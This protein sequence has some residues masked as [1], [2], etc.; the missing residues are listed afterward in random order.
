VI[1]SIP[2]SDNVPAVLELTSGFEKGGDSFPV[3]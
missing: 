2:V 3:I 1:I